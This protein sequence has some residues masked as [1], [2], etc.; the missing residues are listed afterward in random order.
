[1]KTHIIESGVVVNT[2]LATVAEAQAAFPSAICIDGET[3]TEKDVIPLTPL[4][5]YWYQSYHG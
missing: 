2:I 5:V 4:T 3:G 1:M